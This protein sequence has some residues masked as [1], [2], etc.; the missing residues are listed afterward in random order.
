MRCFS[1]LLVPLYECT[2]PVWGPALAE[3]DLDE[4]GLE[5]AW[6]SPFMA[7]SSDRDGSLPPMSP[8][9]LTGLGIDPCELRDCESPLEPIDRLQVHEPYAIGDGADNAVEWDEPDH[10]KKV[11]DARPEVVSTDIPS[12]D[13]IITE[14]DVSIDTAGQSG[15]ASSADSDNE[16]SAKR[17]LR[18]VRGTAGSGLSPEDRLVVLRVL[19]D[20]PTIDRP[21]FRKAVCPLLPR[22]KSGSIDN[23]RAHEIEAGTVRRWLHDYVARSAGLIP[24]RM[25][26]V[27]AGT[28]QLYAS[29][30]L[31]RPSTVR[32]TITVWH[33]YC[34]EPL[35]RHVAGTEPPCFER[36]YQNRKFM[37]LSPTQTRVMIGDLISDAGGILPAVMPLPVIP[38]ATGTNAKE[39]ERSVPDV[40][41]ASSKKRR[42]VLDVIV[43]APTP[44]TTLMPVAS[45]DA[46]RVAHRAVHIPEFANY[47]ACGLWLFAR[48][49]DLGVD[50]FITRM[51]GFY[52]HATSSQCMHQ[53]QSILRG[54]SLPEWAHVYLMAQAGEGWQDR[55]DG[56]V[57]GLDK[58]YRSKKYAIS[59]TPRRL[60]VDWMH[61]CVE[62]LMRHPEGSADEA[63]C[64]RYD[65]IRGYSMVR[66]SEPQR[67]RIFMD[68]FLDEQGT[69]HLQT[70]R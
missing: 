23:F 59:K 39:T 60:V 53:R 55:I 56:I 41:K 24:G 48:E 42:R 22:V 37:S 68:R 13:T 28:K 16:E 34:V 7:P 15:G 35:S 9:V 33:R 52:P 5:E 32:L 49:P 50:E 30:G 69:N 10:V 3:V 20:N 44:T 18:F 21:A 12:I 67:S 1:F 46:T 64:A 25:D 36:T 62:P 4:H 27:V 17:R 43:A 61:Y 51:R 8:F 31:R 38:R 57:F 54:L 40:E 14:S 29:Y 66:L 70:S 58:L 19:Y 47:R 2:D 63:P 26:K 11:F 65:S 45:S 6:Q